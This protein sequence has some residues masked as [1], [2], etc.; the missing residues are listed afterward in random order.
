MYKL[1]ISQEY[2]CDDLMSPGNVIFAANIQFKGFNPVS[3]VLKLY[4][5]DQSS[6]TT[7]P[8]AEHILKIFNDYKTFMKKSEVSS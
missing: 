7:I 2:G 5:T 4:N 6:F 1:Y 8:K 3:S